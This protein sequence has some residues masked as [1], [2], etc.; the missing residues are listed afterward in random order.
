MCVLKKP[1]TITQ[2]VPV[3]NTEE[4]PTKSAADIQKESETE[5]RRLGYSQNGFSSLIATSSFGDLTLPD[6]AVV[7]LSGR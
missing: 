3:T 5:R 7:S 2:A 6:T 4:T 1:K